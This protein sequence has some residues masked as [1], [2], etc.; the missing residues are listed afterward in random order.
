LG[1]GGIGKGAKMA[2]GSQIAIISL[3]LL[4]EFEILYP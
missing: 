1:F 2:G 4:L 3:F